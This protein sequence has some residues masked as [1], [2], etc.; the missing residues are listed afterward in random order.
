MKIALIGPTNLEL[1]SEYSGIE[2]NTYIN[3]AKIL[4]KLIADYNHDLVIVP[5]RG[6]AVAGLNSYKENN[7]KNIIAINPTRGA[8]SYQEK[9]LKCDDNL[10]LC[11][12][13]YSDLAW[14]EQH[15]FICRL[16]D[17]MVCCGLSCGTI[18]EIVWTKWNEKPDVYVCKNTITSIPPEIIAESKVNFIENAEGFEQILKSL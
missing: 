11:N 15:S 5:D 10:K 6:V 12:E 14:C 4:G 13:I 9:T 17:L 8:T 2:I 18:A 16:S 7:G 1:I 3:S